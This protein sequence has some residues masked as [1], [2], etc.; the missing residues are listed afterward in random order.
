M[1][2]TR[3]LTWIYIASSF[4][5]ETYETITIW[6]LLSAELRG[7]QERIE[8]FLNSPETIN[9]FH[10]QSMSGLDAKEKRDNNTHIF[11]GLHEIM[12]QLLSLLATA[13]PTSL[14]VETCLQLIPSSH[15][16]Q[17]KI[18]IQLVISALS[19]WYRSDTANSHV[20]QA[21]ET[22]SNMIQNDPDESIR[23]QFTESITR[24]LA[25]ER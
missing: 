25:N 16:E 5:M 18:N 3:I 4:T 15:T 21:I 17:R 9:L 6:E 2:T 13:Q 11:V 12:P 7:C 20:Q 8:E 14:L 22:L 24:I 23:H 1:I 19:Y 10:T